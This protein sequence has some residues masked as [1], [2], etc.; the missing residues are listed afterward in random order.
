MGATM[1]V[2]AEKFRTAPACVYRA[3]DLGKE[4]VIHHGHYADRVFKLVAISKEEWESERE[5]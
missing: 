2:E 4:V 5:G 3:A 1:K